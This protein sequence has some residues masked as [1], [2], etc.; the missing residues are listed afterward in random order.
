MYTKLQLY[1]IRVGLCNA[2]VYAVALLYGTFPPL[3]HM[4]VCYGS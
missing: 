2:H 4:C 3:Q 1:V